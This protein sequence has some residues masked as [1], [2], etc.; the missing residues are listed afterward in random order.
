MK[1]DTLI[2]FNEILFKGRY[3]SIEVGGATLDI[4][5][6]G[7]LNLDGKVAIVDP[8]VEV[9]TIPLIELM[10]GEEFSK[11][12]DFINGLGCFDV[13]PPEKY[14]DVINYYRDLWYKISQKLERIKL[15]NNRIQDVDL[16][17]DRMNCTLPPPLII[18]PRELLEAAKKILAPTGLLSI[19]TDSEDWYNEFFLE[20]EQMESWIIKNRGLIARL[21]YQAPRSLHD[22]ILPGGERFFIEVVKK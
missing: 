14:E 18:S 20:L 10:K 4:S 11:I 12:P 2:G 6:I 15:I 5:L 13:I 17:G 1:K 3:K 9:V 21:S 16:R 8:K 7:S 22:I 19:Y